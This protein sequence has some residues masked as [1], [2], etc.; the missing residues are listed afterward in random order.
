MN[1]RLSPFAVPPRWQWIVKPAVVTGA[2]GT[3]LAPFLEETAIAAGE[4][5]PL[6]VLPGMAGIIFWFN[7]RVFNSTHPGSKPD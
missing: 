2:G 6:A 7:Q 3:V 5:L 1:S 4:F